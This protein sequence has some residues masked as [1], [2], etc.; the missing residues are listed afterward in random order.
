MEGWG[1]SWGLGEFFQQGVNLQPDFW[2]GSQQNVHGNLPNPAGQKKKKKIKEI[3]SV[4]LLDSRRP[5]YY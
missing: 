2:G 4:F 1:E 3:N 5:K